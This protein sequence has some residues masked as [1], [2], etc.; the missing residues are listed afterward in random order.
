MSLQR[1][2]ELTSDVRGL[3]KCHS[4]HYCESNEDGGN[5]AFGYVCNFEALEV[6]EVF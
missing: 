1:A 2:G 3:E 6:A 5:Y 4:K